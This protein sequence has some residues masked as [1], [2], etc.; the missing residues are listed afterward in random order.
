ML[1]SGKLFDFRIYKSIMSFEKIKKT[2][3][4]GKLKLPLIK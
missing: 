2:I 4:W 3:A 1:F